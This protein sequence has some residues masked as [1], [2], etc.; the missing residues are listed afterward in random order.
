MYS[1]KSSI[2]FLGEK[3]F[4]D[5]NDVLSIMG[6]QIPRV[7]KNKMLYDYVLKMKK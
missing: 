7:F 5:S 6:Q 2:G 3:G 1:P 4:C